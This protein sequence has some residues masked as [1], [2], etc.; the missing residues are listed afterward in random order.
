MIDRHGVAIL[1]D[2][3]FK[4]TFS[5]SLTNSKLLELLSKINSDVQILI[6]RTVRNYNENDIDN[7]VMNTK[8]KLICTCSSGFD[9]IPVDYAKKAGIHSLNVPFGNYISAAEHTFAI[10]LTIVKNI[11]SADKEM[12]SGVFDFSNY[13]NTELNGKTIGVIGVGKIGSYVA[14]LARV[15]DMN[16]LGNDINK[17]KEKKY[18]WIRFI[19]L[20]KLLA[21]SDIITV[22]TPLD[23]STKDLININNIGLIKKHAI[24]INCARG[25][26]I[27]EFAL[28]KI[29]S[30][31]RMFYAGIDVFSAEPNFNKRFAKLDNVILTPHLAGKTI[32][33]KKRMSVQLAE[34]ICNFV[35]NHQKLFN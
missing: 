18:K 16:V 26:I 11:S 8:V 34:Q 10:I 32:E 24:L 19:S 2:S 28:L 4:V 9:N 7:L 3:G 25:K 15:F 14:K 22:H 27:N 20:R 12:K 13:R 17:S 5:E 21:E 1:L 6:I 30:Q 31:H 33:S 23:N 29:L 35:K